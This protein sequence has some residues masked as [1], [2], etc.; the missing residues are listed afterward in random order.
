[1]FVIA[2]DNPG[3]NKV[4]YVHGQFITD[5]L[6]SGQV[7]QDVWYM[8]STDGGV[9]W[10]RLT[11]LTRYGPSDTVRA[12]NSISAVFDLNDNLHIVWAGRHVDAAGNYY[13]A[14][15]IFHWDEVN[16]QITVVSSPTGVFAGGW[17]GWTNPNGYGNWR[18]PADDALLVVDKSSAT[19]LYCL[20]SGQDDITDISAGG[21]PNGDIYGARSIDGGLT[22]SDYV[23]LTN[24]AS[25][26]AAAGACFDEDYISVCPYTV[27]DSIYLTYIE[28]KD[29]GGMPQSE[30]D[31]TDNPVRL[32]VFPTALLGVEEHTSEKPLTVA[33]TVTPNP[34]TRQSVLTYV[35]PQTGDV[36][37]KVYGIDGRLVSTLVQ[38]TQAA[39][40]YTRNIDTRQLASGT[41]FVLF[42]TP[43]KQLSR[44]LVII[45]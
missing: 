13:D 5:T 29:A 42:K 33:L 2:S 23:N 18:L 36:M 12:F 19:T 40:V 1:M 38:G 15:K 11:N 26:G 30:G 44:S 34:A 21:Y 31:T 37:L 8:V 28:D 22:W 27:N 14:S 39:G 9:N 41:Y 17:W 6:G 32:Y 35:V 45:H 7:D 24:T 10:G 20:W 3:S 25:P 16:D 4:V 43:Q